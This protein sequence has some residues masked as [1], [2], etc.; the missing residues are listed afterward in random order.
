MKKPLITGAFSPEIAYHLGEGCVL[1][2]RLMQ[3]AASTLTM[4]PKV[5]LFVLPPVEDSTFLVLK[6][7]LYNKSPASSKNVFRYNFRL[8]LIA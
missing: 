6:F 3:L 2:G 4:I 5:L 1:N 8:Q 7:I